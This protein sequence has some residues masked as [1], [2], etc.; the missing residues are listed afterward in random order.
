MT[1][2]YSDLR[3]FTASARITALAQSADGRVIA[4]IAH[5]DAERSKLLTQLWELP[6][7]D[8][9]AP[10][11][12]TSGT[13]SVSLAGFTASGDALFTRREDRDDDLAALYLLPRGGGEAVQIATAAGFDEVRAS[14]DGRVLVFLSPHYPSAVTS[15][16]DLAV[17]KLRRESGTTGILHESSP[18]R[19]WDHDLAA[20]RPQLFIAELSPLSESGVDAPELVARRVTGLGPDEQI[21]DLRVT[22]D[23]E[24]VL[25]TVT[26]RIRGVDT[27]SRIV[28]I[29]L[30]TGTPGAPGAAVIDTVLAGEHDYR[31]LDLDR[32]GATAIVAESPQVSNAQPVVERVLALDV[33]TGAT[34]PLAPENDDLYEQVVFGEDGE[35]YGVL[36]DHGATRI[37]RIPLDGGPAVR[38]DRVRRH[39]SA[40]AVDERGA[41]T[42]LVDGI[43]AA[44]APFR[45][46]DGEPSPLP[47]PLDPV[48][49]G[50]RLDEVETV[51]AD[52]TPLRAWIALPAEATGRL[53]LLTFIHGGPWGSWNSWTWRWNPWTAVSRGYA[54]LLPDPAI[55]TGYGARMLDRGWSDLGGAPFDDLMRLVDAAVAREDIDPERTAALGGSYGGYMANWIA[56]R[57][58]RFRCIV[59]H[60]GL[61]DLDSFRAGTDTAHHWYAH[62]DDRHNAENSPQAHV[63]RIV[64]PMLIIHGDHDYRVPIGQALE[65][66]TELLRAQQSS[67]GENRNKFLYFPDENHWILKPGNAALWYETV[68]NFCDHHVLG[69]PWRRP[70]LAG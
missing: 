69:K 21:E 1:D 34:R 46:V 4:T 18:V 17:A 67:T 65:L 63:D 29:R 70:E 27:R 10:R 16:D 36:P 38:L 49:A 39:F 66:W 41:V 53:P 58:D 55:S 24:A 26:T 14:R 19:Y 42:G 50:G 5:P 44:P 30:A 60:A 48:V 11:R 47:S 8:G 40:L 12:L 37:V 35:L 28:R 43:D 6:V 31:L 57:T 15:E 54:V 59:S 22:P 2:P 7:A 61:Y 64:T 52:G 62:L 32:S 51:A 3:A 13:A 9:G 68:L 33:A 45:L 56:G 25:A 20:A 23:A